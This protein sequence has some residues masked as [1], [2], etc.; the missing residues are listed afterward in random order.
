MTGT[1]LARSLALQ[2]DLDL[3]AT[4]V[5]GEE[6]AVCRRHMQSTSHIDLTSLTDISS[7]PIWST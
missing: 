2:R 6:V 5:G 3:P 4:V 7:T 1:T